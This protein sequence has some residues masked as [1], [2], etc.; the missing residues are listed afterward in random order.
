MIQ[1]GQTQVEQ[2]PITAV[3]A[4]NGFD[5]IGSQGNAAK[6]DD[7]QVSQAGGDHQITEPL[8]VRQMAFV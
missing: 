2:T 5:P 3:G 1:Q 7:P 6:V 8:R 4:M